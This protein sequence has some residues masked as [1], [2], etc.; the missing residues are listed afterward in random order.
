[1]KRNRA[2]KIF[3]GLLVASPFLFVAIYFPTVTRSWGVAAPGYALG[4]LAVGAILVGLY[5]LTRETNA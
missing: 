1:M 3:G 4:T 5:L 2:L